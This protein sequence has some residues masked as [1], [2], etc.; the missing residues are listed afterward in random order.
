[1]RSAVFFVLLTFMLA[2]CSALGKLIPSKFDNVEYGKLVELNVLTTAHV[3]AEDWCNKAII[4]QLNYRAEYLHTY[5]TYRLNANIAD[6]YKGIYDLTQ[7]L[8][9]K[10]N[11]SDAYC[12]IKRQSIQKITTETLSV[13]GSRKS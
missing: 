12:R 3:S 7:E 2:G 11:P 1:M 8:K 6:I 9:E 5:S 10:E 4:N 13:F